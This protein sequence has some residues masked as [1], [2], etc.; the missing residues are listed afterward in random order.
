M[1]EESQVCCYRIEDKCIHNK[2]L[3]DDSEV[4][5]Q[6]YFAYLGAS[7]KIQCGL[8]DGADYVL[9]EFKKRFRTE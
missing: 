1:K 8:T 2:A 6:A 7:Q 4:W 5:L 3:L 9:Q